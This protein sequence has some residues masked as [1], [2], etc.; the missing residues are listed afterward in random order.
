[1]DSTMPHSYHEGEYELTDT[2]I[3]NGSGS[4]NSEVIAKN[5]PIY[6][7]PFS[8]YREDEQ[9]DQSSDSG[10]S[11][12]AT[13][14][15][16]SCSIVQCDCESLNERDKCLCPDSGRLRFLQMDSEY[17]NISLNLVK[18]VHGGVPEAFD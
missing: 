2:H 6:Q 18:E 15:S 11:M 9:D 13:S 17:V 8:P 4:F 14:R 10:P 7:H 3:K 16:A 5:M 12:T 1:M